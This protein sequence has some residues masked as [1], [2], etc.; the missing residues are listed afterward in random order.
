MD[1]ARR[2]EPQVENLPVTILDPLS[3]GEDHIVELDIGAR[4]PTYTAKIFWVIAFYNAA[5]RLAAS[6]GQGAW[7]AAALGPAAG[8]GIS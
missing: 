8:A 6:S 5:I 7:A 3:G 2:A 4:P 1:I